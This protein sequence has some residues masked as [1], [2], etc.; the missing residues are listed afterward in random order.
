[1]PFNLLEASLNLG[2]PEELYEFSV[3][4]AFW[5]VTSRSQPS[6]FKGYDWQPLPGLRRTKFKQSRNGGDDSIKLY[7]PIDFEITKMFDVAAPPMPIGLTVYRHHRGDGEEYGQSW[8][9]RI[10]GCEWVDGATAILHGD[11][12][13]SMLSRHTLR[14]TFDHR[15]PHML[16]D[17]GCTLDPENFKLTAPV[18][19]VTKNTIVSPMFATKPNDWLALGFVKYNGYRFMISGH[20]ADTI[21]V[22]TP[23]NLTRLPQPV[24]CEAYA[25]CDHLLDTCWDKFNNGLNSEAN[26]WMPN[27][28]PFISGI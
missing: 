22:F 21:S 13:N 9:G 2:R 24:I 8:A 17:A 15:C 5:R 10:R 12:A 1:M 20:A 28:N 25:G 6:D 14:L 4:D 19:S 27:R 18:A 11:G 7:T 16:Y 26:P 23:V 3:G